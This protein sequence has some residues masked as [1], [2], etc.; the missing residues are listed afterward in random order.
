MVSR[1][2]NISR[3]VSLF[4]FLMIRRPPRSTL[5]PYTTLFRSTVL[6][7]FMVRVGGGP[8]CSAT[9]D[10][11]KSRIFSA[12]AM[13]KK[14]PSARASCPACGAITH[15]RYDAEDASC[16]H[17]QQRFNPQIGTVSGPHVQC[18][19]CDARFKLVDRMKDIDGPLAYRRYAKMILLQDGAKVYESMNKYDR[20]MEKMLAEENG[21]L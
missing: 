18:P 13:P 15:T 11:F 21:A 7:Y 1:Y 6:Y 10:L 9:S 20:E 14:D 8:N 5:F 16:P 2:R 19:H 3:S 17:C 4:F 12:N